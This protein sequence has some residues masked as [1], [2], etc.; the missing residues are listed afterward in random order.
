MLSPCKSNLTPIHPPRNPKHRQ[1]NICF[2]RA[3]LAATQM[4]NVVALS[5][6]CKVLMHAF[7]P[8]NWTLV[9]PPTGSW[10]GH[11]TI[12]TTC[13]KQKKSSLKQVST[14]SLFAYANK[15][16]ALTVYEFFFCYP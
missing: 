14:P 5:L 8:W 10:L 3:A 16:Q 7:S 13:T 1:V 4:P 12:W 9:P 15:Q 11:I 6:V 2:K